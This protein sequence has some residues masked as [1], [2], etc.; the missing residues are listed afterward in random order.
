LQGP[1]AESIF[2]KLVVTVVRRL[3]VSVEVC[4]LFDVNIT[5]PYAQPPR[6]PGWDWSSQR[7]RL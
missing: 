5:H 6:V 1:A 3:Y 2:I 7:L 4:A